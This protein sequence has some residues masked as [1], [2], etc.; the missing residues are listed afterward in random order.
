MSEV[1]DVVV[2]GAGPAGL[3]AARVAGSDGAR[4]ALVDKMGPGG[5]LMNIGEVHDFATAAPGQS[6]PDLIGPM[7]DAALAAGVE[8]LV[9]EVVRVEGGRTWRV[10]M[11]DEAAE[12]RVIIVATG[13]SP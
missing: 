11:L 3:A 12:A 4:V 5:Q 13:L 2:I 7:V 6:G 10:S 8:M 9:D 1:Y